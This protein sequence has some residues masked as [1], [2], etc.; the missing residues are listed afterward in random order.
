MSGSFWAL[1]AG[2]AFG[3]FQALNRRFLS[4][5]SDAFLTAAPTVFGA[6]TVLT[7]TVL[8]TGGF[9]RVAD[10]SIAALVYFGI[11][12]LFHSVLGLT[13]LNMSHRLVGGARTG[14][15][16]TT[17]VLFGALLAALIGA[18][19]PGPNIWVGVALMLAGVY[20]IF[21]SN[22]LTPSRAGGTRTRVGDS[23]PGLGVGMAWGFSAVL[24]R[25]GLKQGVSPV[26]GLWV[27]LATAGMTYA[28]FVLIVFVLIRRAR[29]TK[30]TAELG[31]FM[32]G[33]VLG[34]ALLMMVAALQREEVATVLALLQVQVPAVML[35]APILTRVESERATSR[36]AFGAL[37]VIA[38]SLL[39]IFS[40]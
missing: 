33:S 26:H 11:A 23:L 7:V 13:L 36:V 39:L 40:S 5:S 30:G 6:A 29:A 32:T 9:E 27:A 21:G 37:L 3:V 2:M 1:G 15:L 20:V 18:E 12:G 24:I 4:P 8:A 10:V 28:V 35:L 14:P 34:V 31:R 38:S 17:N 22:A 19:R 25:L 16:V